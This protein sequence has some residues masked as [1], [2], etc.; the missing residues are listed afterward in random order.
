MFY[1][2][3]IP[4]G[5]KTVE[6]TFK[7]REVMVGFTTSYSPQRQGWFLVPA[8]KEGNNLRVFVVS[9]AVEIVRMLG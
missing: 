4:G 7:D 1:Q 9:S 5:G 3:D 6:V 2:D 8:D